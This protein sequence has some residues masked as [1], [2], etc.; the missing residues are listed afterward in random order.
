[1]LNWTTAALLAASAV[2]SP[3]APLPDHEQITAIPPELEAQFQEHVIRKGDSKEERLRLL[4]DFVLEAPG[5]NL[6]YDVGTTRTVAET[7]RARKANCLSFTLLFIALAREAGLKAS[8]Q[9]Y[10]QVLVWYL[11]DGLVFNSSHVNARVEAGAE[12]QTVDVGRNVL[13]SRYRPKIISD[14]RALSFYY[15]NRGVELMADGDLVGAGRHLDAAVAL[16]PD[17]AAVWSNL[18]VLS[19]RRGDAPSAERRY[20]KAL[21]LDSRHGAALANIVTLYQRTDRPQ[22]AADYRRRLQRVQFADPFHQFMM[23]M[24][25]EKRGQFSMAASYYRR[26]TRLH[27]SE[28]A[29][30]LGLARVYSAMGELRRAQRSLTRAY[31]LK[32]EN[33]RKAL[34]AKNEERRQRAGSVARQVNH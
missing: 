21:E 22:L 16:E 25:Y 34:Q 19:L 2:S 15:N 30:Y 7:Y 28:P 9:E 13:I 23:G 29:F 14:E 32:D 6:Q 12:R 4:I 1:M 24:D 11:Q 18:G 5:L 3:G 27:D 31:A 26:A 33:A 17:D 10:E 20:H 8:V